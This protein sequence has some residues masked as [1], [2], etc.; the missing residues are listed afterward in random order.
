[1]YDYLNAEAKGL[2]WL[3]NE[4]YSEEYKQLSEKWKNQPMYQNGEEVKKLVTALKDKS[5]QVIVAKAGTGTG[6]TVLIPKM[7][8]KSEI[9]ERSLNST[10]KIAMT[11]PKTISTKKAGEY[12]AQLLDTTLGKEV[13][14]IYRESS[15]KAYHKFKTRLIYMTDGFLLATSLSDPNFS[16]YS[17]II[18]DEAHERGTNI[19]FLLYKI[20]KALRVR[21]N[22]LKVIIISATI[23]PK[24]FTDYFD[25]SSDN[26]FSRVVVFSPGTSKA[27]KDVFLPPQ[28]ANMIHA[29]RLALKNDLKGNDVALYFVPTSK[30]TEK[31]IREVKKACQEGKLDKKCLTLGYAP[32]YSKLSEEDQ[33]L[34]IGEVENSNGNIH[35][36][37]LE[38]PFTNKLV[39][40][41]NIAE[42]SVTINN[43]KVVIDSGKEFE[44]VWNPLFHASV[45]G[46]VKSSNA[47]IQQRR[48]RVGRTNPGT[49]YYLYDKKDFETRAKYPLPSI[50]KSNLTEDALKL[51]SNVRTVTQTIIEFNTFLTP[52][53]PEQIISCLHS[54]Y[55]VGL[56]KI[57]KPTHSNNS[58]N[59]VGS[60]MGLKH[61][62]S[63]LV[64][65]NSKGYI[66]T[67]G[68]L[69]LKLV[70][71][72]NADLW[73]ILPIMS[74]LLLYDYNKHTREITD[75]VDLFCVL[76]EFNKGGNDPASF[77]FNIPN[78]PIQKAKATDYQSFMLRKSR[79][80]PNKE[81]LSLLNLFQILDRHSYVNNTLLERINDRKMF[82]RINLLESSFLSS[83]SFLKAKKD[84]MQEDNHHSFNILQKL[85]GEKFNHIDKCVIY[86]RFNHI[87]KPF[88]SSFRTMATLSPFN[89]NFP[90]PK[91]NL[92]NNYCIYE[93]ANIMAREGDSHEID[94]AKTKANLKVLTSISVSLNA[95]I[96]SIGL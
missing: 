94:L 69:A 3:N 24:V 43:L 7:A 60:N 50:L 22:D 76:E 82:I 5:V 73:N 37:L 13:G 48:G 55:L 9:E 33:K 40:S 45:M 58:V 27:I 77:F 93:S 56:I 44:N 57:V 4:E 38:S 10:W 46:R 61:T 16:A 8:L 84:I 34:A 23:D 74:G 62:F 49:V 71:M 19:D 17:M 91:S 18:I 85:Q 79:W 28:E 51:L 11:I 21:K 80:N 1:M 36:P 15:E 70:K 92:D 96:N 90:E 29:T 88:Q 86:A 31:G 89:G 63:S 64:Q 26:A 20:K 87:C 72:L 66:S 32:L 53:R 83:S 59:S 39:F 35:D 52:P 67:M 30:D 81:H 2:N 68:V 25:D 14:F 54:L 75:I 41:T 47:Q 42:S 78:S 12:S 6:K 95:F 65:N